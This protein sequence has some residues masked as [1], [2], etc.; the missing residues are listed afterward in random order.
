MVGE[1]FLP[2]EEEDDSKVMQD[3]VYTFTYRKMVAQFNIYYMDYPAAETQLRSILADELNFF[4][5]NVKK[6]EE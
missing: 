1:H 6:E 4:K 2:A 3:N 5:M